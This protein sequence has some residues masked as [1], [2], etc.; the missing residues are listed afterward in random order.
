[1]KIPIEVTEWLACRTGGRTLVH[2]PGSFDNYAQSRLSCCWGQPLGGCKVEGTPYR[3]AVCTPSPKK[4]GDTL[5]M[6]WDFAVDN[7]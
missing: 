7:E 3:V 5:F 2:N 1:M 6:Y 4:A